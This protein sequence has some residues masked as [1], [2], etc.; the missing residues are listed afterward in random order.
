MAASA[1]KYEAIAFFTPPDHTPNYGLVHPIPLSEDESP[2]TQPEAPPTEAAT[3]TAASAPTLSAPAAG[4]SSSSYSPP[5]VTPILNGTFNLHN[6]YDF[7][8]LLS[9]KLKQKVFRKRMACQLLSSHRF[10]CFR[11][12]CRT[13]PIVSDQNL[14]YSSNSS[15]PPFRLNPFPLLFCSC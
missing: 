6:P 10:I 11:A 1:A 2:W 12:Y 7:Q 8:N 14:Q 9:G 15:S 5:M 4:P 3:V 13:F